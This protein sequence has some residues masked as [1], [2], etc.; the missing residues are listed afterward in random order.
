VRTEQ[1]QALEAEVISGVARSIDGTTLASSED[2]NTRKILTASFGLLL[3]GLVGC[4]QGF[5]P[6]PDTHVATPQ[7]GGDVFNNGNDTTTYK[8]ASYAVLQGTL[9]Q[10]MKV[11][12]QPLSATCTALGA[13]GCPLNAPLTFLAANK[14]AL[15]E[16]VYNQAD[17]LNTQA[18]GPMTS[19]GF[20]VWILASSSACG[21]MMSQTAPALYP[22]GVND[23]SYMYQSLLGRAPS[24]VEIDRLNTLQASWPD[25]AHQ[26]AASCTAVLG[27]LEFLMVN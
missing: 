15:G 1:I 16:P 20:K 22:N 10:I 3:T 24:Q 19:G 8:T 11:S 9:T 18:P 2:M 5:S 26:G 14:A 4:G 25:A 6:S 7:G 27:S 21:I 23:Y 12:D 13:A 17:P